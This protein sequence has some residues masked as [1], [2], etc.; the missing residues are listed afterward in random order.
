MPNRRELSKA[1]KAGYNCAVVGPNPTNC[2]FTLFSSREAT[3]MW[4]AGNQDA[5]EK[6]IVAQTEIDKIGK[7]K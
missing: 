7:S 3:K 6:L 4:E 5:I 2:N 1:Y